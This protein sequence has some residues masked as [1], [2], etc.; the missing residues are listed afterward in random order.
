MTG[1]T[2]NDPR[3]VF[4]EAAHAYT[5]GERRLPSVTQILADVGVADF[6]KPHFTEDV[7]ERGR[8]IH[9]A[10]ALDNEGDLD[11]ETLDPALQPY[12]DGWRRFLAESGARV[13][14]WERP[15]CDPEL[16][17]AGTLDGVIVLP[18]TGVP[19][20]TVLDV[21]RA[22]YPSAGPQ[23]AAYTRCA[24][25]LYEGPVL[26]NRAALV[27]PGDGS[28]RLHMLVDATDEYTFLAALRL[29]HWRRQH[30]VAA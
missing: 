2:M 30:G 29:Y 20:K 5:L 9:L 27:L 21:K 19:R 24:R 13:E 16:G 26:F 18:S 23:V 4:D 10:I 1:W 6:S 22:L 12:I 3:L 15:V 28:Y 25:A 8:L 11:D 14:H 17:F 7:A